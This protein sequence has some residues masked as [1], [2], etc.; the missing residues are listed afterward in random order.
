MLGYF[1]E[2]FKSDMEDVKK[3]SNHVSEAIKIAKAQVDAKEHALQARERYEASQ[4]RNIVSHLF[5]RTNDHQNEAR[6]W[7]LENE[8]RRK[9]KPSRTTL[10]IIGL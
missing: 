8:V 4:S 10:N 2:E 1:D 5:K 3:C 6:A 9:C 7:Q